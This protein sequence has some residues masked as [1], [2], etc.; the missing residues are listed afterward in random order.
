VDNKCSWIISGVLDIDKECK[1]V[2]HY[3]VC[4]G[5]LSCESDWPARQ[6]EASNSMCV[7]RGVSLLVWKISRCIESMTTPESEVW[8]FRLQSLGMCII[9]KD[10]VDSPKPTPTLPCIDST[11]SS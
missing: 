9:F 8:T 1:A 11:N 6:L 7:E 10:C 4:M 2:P 5:P 3:W